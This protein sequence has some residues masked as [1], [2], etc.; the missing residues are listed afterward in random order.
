LNAADKILSLGNEIGL[1]FD[2]MKYDIYQDKK[3]FIEYVEQELKLLSRALGTKI[4]VVSMHRPSKFTLNSN[5]KYSDTV[6][7]YSEE[8]FHD[9]KYISDSRMNWREDAAD[10]IQN[11]VADKLHI[12]THPFWYNINI[13][14]T[15]DKLLQFIRKSGKERYENLSCNLKD[16]EEFVTTDDL[17]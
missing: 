1:H 9:F 4:Q 16:L 2:E 11:N 8:F 12:L 17:E 5:F 6:N 13:E 14:N 7:S 15:R 3:L 10:I